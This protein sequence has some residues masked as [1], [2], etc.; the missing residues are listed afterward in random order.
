MLF[1]SGK[2]TIPAHMKTTSV[3]LAAVFTLT[4][5]ASAAII[6]PGADGSDG[7]LNITVDTVIDLSQ[8]PTG[9]WDANNTA[10]AGKGIYDPAK[11]AVVFKYSSVTIAA[12][13]TVTFKNH[14][15]RAPV[16]WLVNGSVSIA[17]TVSLDGAAGGSRPA[18][19]VLAEPGPGGFRGGAGYYEVGSG[20]LGSAGFGVG[21]GLR[22]GG[23]ENGFGGSYGTQ[24]DNGPAT[25]GNPSLIP[26]LGGSGGAGAYAYPAGGGGGG[27]IMI[28]CANTLTIGGTL[29]AN[30]GNGGQPNLRTG[31]AGS[32]GG[33]R[34]VADSFAGA[35]AVQ[36]IGGSNGYAGG[37]GRVRI[38]RVAN[39]A[40]GAITPDPSLVP[41]T[42]G[43]T[44]L[45]WPPAG[46]PE[47]RVV[48]IGGAAAPTDPRASFGSAGAD[49]A[50]PETTS[51]QVI[52]ETT[53]VE[54]ASQVQVRVAPRANGNATVVN[55]TVASVVSP[56]PLVVRWTASLPVNAGF[57]AVQVKVVRP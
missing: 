56:S 45:L 25:Y 28:A 26:L 55:A 13:K 22:Q 19:P 57:S 5:G 29:R 24:G 48:S 16:A 42:A 14:A 50:L 30:G 33:I 10:N 2:E 12:G 47:V 9:L 49:V 37:L 38:E 39:S 11:W 32:G 41:L 36:A 18:P 15:S 21:G 20:V 44:A 40:T 23:N 17:G 1:R 52:I 53:N 8:A 6:V 3:L 35:G 7:V 51:T 27:A 4:L 54:Q 46:A 34:L 43:D 31:G